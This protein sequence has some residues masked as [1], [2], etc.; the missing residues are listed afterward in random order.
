MFLITY[1]NPSHFFVT[2]TIIVRNFGNVWNEWFIC[3]IIDMLFSPL[4]H[5]TNFLHITKSFHITALLCISDLLQFPYMLLLLSSLSFLT[6]CLHITNL[7]YYTD[8][9][10][11]YLSFFKMLAYMDICMGGRV[12]EELV[13]GADNVTSGT[14]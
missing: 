7:S 3:N 12:A 5:V 13:Y 8:L 14:H 10:F 9:S 11:P 6:C 2:I 4:Y 1:W